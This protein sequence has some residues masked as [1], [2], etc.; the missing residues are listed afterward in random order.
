MKLLRFP[1]L[2]FIMLMLA[3]CGGPAA[4]NE[5]GIISDIQHQDDFFE[6]YNLVIDSSSITKRQTN[7]DDKTDYIWVELTASNDEFIYSAEYSLYYVLYNEGWLLEECDI[8]HQQYEA[9][10]YEFISQADTDKIVAE[11]G[12]DEYTYL[13]KETSF[14]QVDFYYNA[15]ISEMFLRTDYA[16]QL[17]YSFTPSFGWGI[18]TITARPLNYYPDL[19]GTWKSNQYG[20]DLTINVLSLEKTG[21]NAYDLTFT[22]EFINAAIDGRGVFSSRRTEAHHTYIQNNPITISM[23]LDTNVNNVQDWYCEHFTLTATDGSSHEFTLFVFVGG[24]GGL[25]SWNTNESADGCGIGWSEWQPLF[26]EKIQD[27]SKSAEEAK[28]TA[29]TITHGSTTTSYNVGEVSYFY[30]SSQ[31]YLTMT[32]YGQYLG[33]DTGKSPAD[34]P[35]GKEG[36]TYHDY[37]LESA[38]SDM[39]TVTALYDASLA[40]KDNGVTAADVKEDVDAAIDSA[41]QAAQQY[42]VSYEQYLAASYSSYVSPSI[43]EDCV[44]RNLIANEYLSRYQ[45]SLDYTTAQLTTYYDERTDQ[46]DTFQYSYLYFTPAAVEATDANGNDIEMTDGENV[47]AEEKNQIEART[48]ANDA[49]D[50][51]KYGISVETVINE[52]TP[53]SYGVDENTQGNKLNSVYSEWLQDIARKEGDVTLIENDNN[54]FYVVKFQGRYLDESPSV[55]TRHILIQAEMD[56]DAGSPT[57]EQ[58]AAAKARAEALLEQWKAGAATEKTFAE[59]ANANSDDDGSS[60]NGGLYE[61]VYRGQFVIN[62]NEWLFDSTRQPGDASIVENQGS[63]FGYHVVY[64]VKQNKDYLSWMARCKESLA[65]EDTE[66][67]LE[68][69]ESDCIIEQA[70]GV[71]Y[72]G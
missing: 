19:I 41:K 28:E 20:M 33:Y 1:I 48:R 8:S 3:S 44:T 66:N 60:T 16:I 46:F 9:R 29:I 61:K 70:N 22:C 42:G 7:Q 17:S 43:F 69:L 68:R 31:A 72:L 67:W 23:W 35:Y 37:F 62:Y 32:Y 25:Y 38:L 71:R 6:N 51:L 59:L 12:Y 15:S 4:K 34:Q 10:D 26:F 2:L 52:F 11:S 64:Y 36:Q 18:P 21:E 65:D 39:T 45:D 30:H 55:D 24:Q 56:E 54:G 14:N 40:D 13:S 57:E 47:A 49:M 27:Y 50:A 53:I 5:S 58:M 63:Y